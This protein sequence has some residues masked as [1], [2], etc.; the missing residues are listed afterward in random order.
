V[1]RKLT[2]VL[3]LVLAIA[4]A[5]S[6]FVRGLSE[7]NETRERFAKLRVGMNASEVE[8]ELQCSLKTGFVGEGTMNDTGEKCRLVRLRFSNAKI[9]VAF[10]A[11]ETLV[12]KQYVGD[13]ETDDVL[14]NWFRRFKFW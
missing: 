6:F 13:D 10:G 12:W 9:I 1:K 4:L 14:G 11:S 5:I 3:L 2:F 8:A 7:P